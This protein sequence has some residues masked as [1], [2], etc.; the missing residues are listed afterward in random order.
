[1]ESSPQCPGLSFYT[2]KL[3]YLEVSDNVRGKIMT[4]E[5]DVRGIVRR[6]SG[7]KAV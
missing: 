6:N 1:M 4:A 5:Q 2:E 3:D 7:L